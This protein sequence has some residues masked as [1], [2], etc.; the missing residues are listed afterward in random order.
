MGHW[1][2]RDIP[3]RQLF[4]IIPEIRNLAR[5]GDQGALLT[6]HFLSAVQHS[7]FYAFVTDG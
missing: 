5:H 6:A 3:R 2:A 1:H 7:H 4:W